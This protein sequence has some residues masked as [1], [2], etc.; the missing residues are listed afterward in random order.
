MFK[1]HLD[2]W[3]IRFLVKNLGKDGFKYL[4]QQFHSNVLD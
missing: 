3:L 1:L 4:I 2:F